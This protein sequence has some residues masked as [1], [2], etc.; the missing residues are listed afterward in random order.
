[1]TSLLYGPLSTRSLMVCIDMQRLFLEPGEWFAEPG[2]SILPQCKRLAQAGEERCLFTR[3]I[4]ANNAAGAR[5]TWQRYYRRWNSVTRDAIGEQAMDI[6][7]ILQPYASPAQ[8]F[9]KLTH[10]A[11]NSVPFARHIQAADPDAL[12]LFGIETDVCVLA[13]ALSAVDL[14]YRVIVVLDAC[15]SSAPESH[16]ACIE[17]IYP[18]FDQQIELTNTAKLLDAWNAI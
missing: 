18:R 14:G 16:A 11:F 2:V 7:S 3:F 4:T 13:T 5:G 12:V 6:H 9:D 17:H 8:C 15:A 10:D 1:M